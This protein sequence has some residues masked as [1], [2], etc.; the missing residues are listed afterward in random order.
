MKPIQLA[1]IALSICLGSS[2]TYA[3]KLRCDYDR[4]KDKDKGFDR[5]KDEKGK[6]VKG[7][8][9][10]KFSG[11][12]IVETKWVD[13][14]IGRSIY[15]T[16]TL[17][18]RTEGDDSYLMLS[19]N[20]SWPKYTF[21]TEDEAKSNFTILPG[22]DLMIGMSDGSVLTLH[23]AEGAAAA[24]TVTTPSPRSGHPFW[25]HSVAA[26][27]YFL[28]PKSMEAFNAAEARALRVVTDSA[29]LDI[30][31]NGYDDDKVV[32]TAVRCLAGGPK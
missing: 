17:A 5:A 16:G 4:S 31:L 24:T 29:N 6:T 15:T 25:I 21:P 23:A 30:R 26:T 9:I 27:E 3:A 12:L 14:G 32:Q 8:Y 2:D 18:T 13:I 20:H 10:D 11:D 1:L 28:D 22:A 7:F 19:I